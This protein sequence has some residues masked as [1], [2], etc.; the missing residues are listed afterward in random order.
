MSWFQRS[1]GPPPV[2]SV[3][4]PDGG[5]AAGAAALLTSDR[6]L[7]CA[8]VVNEALGLP[9]LSTGRPADGDLDVVFARGA[10]RSRARVEVW[11]PPRSGTAV[12]HGDLCVLR[13]AEPAPE[14][15][16][17]VVWADMT[18]RQ[19]LRAWHG[20]G[21]PVTFADVEMKLLDQE[22]GYLDGELSGAA[23][24][25][26][27]SGGPLW[28]PS[29]RTAVGLVV[30]RLEPPGGAVAAG[31]T[32]RR[33]WA[34]PWQT[35]R[36][37]LDRVGA[38]A[39]VTTCRTVR[40]VPAHDP[41]GAG[42]VAVLRELLPAP[43]ARVEPARHLAQE[44]KLDPPQ[45]GSAPTVEELAAELLTTERA[46]P[47]LSESLVTGPDGRRPG[48]LNTLLALGRVIE[49]AGLLSHGEYAF[50]EE[51]LRDVTA[52][53]N[54]LPARAAQEALRFTQPPAA[55]CEPVLRP[56]AVNEVITGLEGC[57]EGDPGPED[58]PRVPSLVHVVEF[59]A[60]G[61]PDTQRQAL[62]DWSNRVCGRLGVHP[63]ARNQRRADARQ[64]AG[65]RTAPRTRLLARLAAY[66]P[67]APGCFRCRLWQ[68][69]P[70]GSRHRMDTT[71]GDA[72][73]T[74]EQV[75][76]VIRDGAERLQHDTSSQ[77]PAVDIEV[78][79]AGLH[80]PVDEWE[81][82]RPNDFEPSLPLGVA[83][84]L[85]LRCP[86]M[87]R[88]VPMRDAERQRRW[89]DGR[90][91]PLAIGREHVD[92]REV[93]ALLRSTHLDANQVVLHGPPELRDQ[94]LD[95]CLALGVPVVLWDREA[96][97]HDHAARLAPLAP[98]G[99][100]HELPGRVHRYRG[101]TLMAPSAHAARPSLVWE[102]HTWDGLA[103]EDPELQLT[104]P[105]EGAL[106]R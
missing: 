23:I 71:A 61:L 1:A 70:D 29:C 74:A 100:L 57:Q 83:F 54:T 72:P 94:L 47:T 98:T 76:T 17:P 99:P 18:Q 68:Q 6:V 3:H 84:Q 20:C 56:E 105:D 43:A 35:V 65:L 106:S 39:V 27:F 12:W 85:T 80:L 96:L 93:A 46:L 59:I 53:D 19:T 44:L 13:L 97:G 7:T 77:P 81:T 11:V 2:V 62:Q 33:A 15:A 30:G 87:S 60:A 24:G 63:V 101:Q 42:L 34:L 22:V 90:G 32:V 45:D 16:P 95:L 92:S 75:A 51:R 38:R 50:L 31:H 25:P 4:A 78:D 86:E 37:E 73:L 102:D 69:R 9:Q 36:A 64:W 40:T 28:T 14:W 67:A 41:V 82:G 49:A 58:T 5:T 104:D 55:L 21:D 91:R 88:R 79:R 52:W 26:G 48:R 10:S 8:H 103:H 89:G 66:G